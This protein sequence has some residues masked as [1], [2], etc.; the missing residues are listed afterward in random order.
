[1]RLLGRR[2]QGI[3]ANPL[4]V[5]RDV[6]SVQQAQSF[7]ESVQLTLNAPSGTADLERVSTHVPASIV[8]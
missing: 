3:G 4:E 5:L 2:A 7:L 1:M 8:P 6:V